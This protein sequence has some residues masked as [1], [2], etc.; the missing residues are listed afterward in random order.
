MTRQHICALCQSSLLLH[1]HAPGV[2]ILLCV[3]VCVCLCVRIH[4]C[5]LLYAHMLVV[6][7]TCITQI[8]TQIHMTNAPASSTLAHVQPYWECGGQGVV[9]SVHALAFP[10]SCRSVGPVPASQE[11]QTDV[12]CQ[13]T[14][15]PANGSLALLGNQAGSCRRRGGGLVCSRWSPVDSLEVLSSPLSRDH[16]TAAVLT[17]DFHHSMENLSVTTV[18]TVC[19]A[20]G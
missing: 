4:L 9:L 12:C 10:S 2:C 6:T 3:C 20:K 17:R 5:W 1:S 16:A 18:T 11:L 7:H 15:H 14:C 13:G 19:A 8:H